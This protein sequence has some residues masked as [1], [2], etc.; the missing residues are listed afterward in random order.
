MGRKVLHRLG[1]GVEVLSYVEK[2]R[3]RPDIQPRKPEEGNVCSEAI[4]HSRFSFS[5]PTLLSN[6]TRL[7][8][9][10]ILL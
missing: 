6:G 4:A 5:L 10:C 2:A 1:G 3:L 8:G 9:G 7:E